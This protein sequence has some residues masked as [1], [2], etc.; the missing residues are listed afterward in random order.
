[1]AVYKIINIYNVKFSGYTL[2]IQE[3]IYW[4]FF[5]LHNCTL[6]S[7]GN[8]LHYYT[9]T[10]CDDNVKASGLCNNRTYSLLIGKSES[11][12]LKVPF[13]LNIIEQ[14]CEN[15]EEIQSSSSITTS[16]TG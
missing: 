7:K 1:M 3:I 15:N 14:E 11:I 9:T 8:L 5:N 12:Y 16:K 13:I 10:K 4:Q 2:H 6:K